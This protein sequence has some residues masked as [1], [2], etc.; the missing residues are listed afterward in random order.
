MNYMY[1]SIVIVILYH[2]VSG[3]CVS[4]SMPVRSYI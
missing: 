1:Y 3:E 2:S 4:V